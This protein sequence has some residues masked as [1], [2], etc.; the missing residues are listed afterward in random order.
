MFFICTRCALRLQKATDNLQP[1]SRAFSS[2]PSK[3]SKG[4]LPTFTPTSNPE[5][6]AALSSFRYK[7]FLPA[8]L[9]KP[10]QKLI[11]KH[12]NRAFLAE[13]PQTVTLGSE[14]IQLEWIDRKL[15]GIPNR[16]KLLKKT[17]KLMADGETSD[18][19]NLPALLT[20][21]CKAKR[22]PTD[23]QLAK[24]VRLAVNKGRFGTVLQCLHQAHNTGMS[25]K[26]PE[27]LDAVVW[28]LREIAQKG[29]WSEQSLE[30]A[31][32]D[33]KEVAMRL[34]DLEHGT[35]KYVGKGDPRRRP[36]VLGVFLE[37]AAVYASRFQDG[38]DV[39]GKVKAY[40]ERLLANIEGAERVS[41][42][43]PGSK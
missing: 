18:W 29:K 5:L 17:V 13:N 31:I 15:G 6:D 26:K 37:L 40:A 16:V 27:V 21:L 3:R 9:S 24:M 8:A 2:S 35:G 22:T 30:K 41:C 20:G 34:E 33:A 4:A 42:I 11:F 1:I 39:D 25:M 32:R 14:E 38:K 43:P 23:R 10:E 12:R 36:E 7:H 28:G 19:N